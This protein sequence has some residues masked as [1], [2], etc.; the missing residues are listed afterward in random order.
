MVYLCALS[1]R[2]V[3]TAGK[4]KA[5]LVELDLR[6]WPL[7]SLHVPSGNTGRVEVLEGDDGCGSGF[8]RRHF[9]TFR[10]DFSWLLA[11]ASYK[12]HLYIIYSQ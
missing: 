11:V 2:A 6:S 7:D 1:R 12:S 5:S 3:L 4:C 10:V 9:S 8:Q